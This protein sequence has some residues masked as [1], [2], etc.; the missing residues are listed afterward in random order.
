MTRNEHAVKRYYLA[1]NRHDEC[2]MSKITEIEKT[3]L[4]IPGNAW[5]RAD[6]YDAQCKALRDD[7]EAKLKLLA[8]KEDK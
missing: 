3:F 8:A 1:R 2:V 6:D 7:Y 4:K 5:V